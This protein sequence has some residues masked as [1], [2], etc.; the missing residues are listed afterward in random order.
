MATGSVPRWGRVNAQ[1]ARA[2]AGLGL[3]LSAATGRRD[4]RVAR[5]AGERHPVHH[6]A[7]LREL[8][9]AGAVALVA[10]PAGML[11]RGLRRML[12]A[13]RQHS[14]RII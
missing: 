2:P 9:A 12:E 11:H 5:F 14:T 10:S 8:A 13:L 7:R 1:A 4:R 3:R 6:C